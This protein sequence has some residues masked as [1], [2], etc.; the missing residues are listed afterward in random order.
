M[1]PSTQQVSQYA[2]EDLTIQQ[3]ADQ[4]QSKTSPAVAAVYPVAPYFPAVASAFH[5]ATLNQ[6]TVLPVSTTLSSSSTSGSAIQT[7]TA[8]TNKL[9]PVVVPSPLNIAS[10]ASYTK[11]YYTVPRRT[12]SQPT[13][14]VRNGNKV[15]CVMM[16]PKNVA[17]ALMQPVDDETG[18]YRVS[19]PPVSRI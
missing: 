16:P 8:P 13:F 15:Q 14:L 2:S 12:F 11:P 19:S 5:S 3:P 4:K 1:E 10:L 9:P 7:T 6:S 17:G 18:T